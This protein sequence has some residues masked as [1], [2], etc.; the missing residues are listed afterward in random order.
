V[1]CVRTAS[2]GVVRKRKFRHVVD[3]GDEQHAL[4]GFAHRAFHL[5]VAVVADHEDGVAL[6]RVANRFHVDLRDERARR[7]DDAQ[8]AR[9]R[10]VADGGG[11]AVGAEDG[12]G[13]GRHLI[14]FVHEDRPSAAKTFDDVE[15]V[16][17]LLPHVDRRI[18]E[19]QGALD[20]F[21]GAFD[22]GA[23]AAGLAR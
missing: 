15:V 7:V 19:V 3:G 22:A 13:T 9:H 8:T 11:D 20:D 6:F 5:F 17:D 2:T 4:G 10:I 1:V 14:E 23:E 21:D 12:D 16:D 18:E